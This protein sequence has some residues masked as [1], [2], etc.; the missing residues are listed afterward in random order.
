MD[1]HSQYAA[2]VAAEYNSYDPSAFPGSRQWMANKK[3]A[4]ALAAFEAEHPGIAAEVAAK[5]EEKPLS[6]A[7][8]RALRGED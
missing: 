1:L 8:Q 4:A 7:A 6:E 3:A 2:L 5:R